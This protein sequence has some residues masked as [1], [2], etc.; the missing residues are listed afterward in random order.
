MYILAGQKKL[1]DQ[2]ED[3]NV[4]LTINKSD[5]AGMMESIEEYL[6]SSCCVVIMAPFAYII[7][8]AIIVQT[9]DKYP[10]HAT[11][12]NEMIGRMLH[13]PRDKSKTS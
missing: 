9:Y 4:L 8:K 2:Y 1:K 3:P 5:M 6:R 13:M 10:T 12:D 7:R 11:S